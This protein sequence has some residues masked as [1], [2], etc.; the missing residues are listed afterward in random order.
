MSFVYPKIN[1]VEN[2][3]IEK[4]YTET[5]SKYFELIELLS[6]KLITNYGQKALQLID[7]NLLKTLVAIREYYKVP[8]FIN[9]G[10]PDFDERIVRFP[11]SEV[12]SPGSRHSAVIDAKGNITKRSDACDFDVKGMTAEQVRNDIR[13]N[14]A[15]FTLITAIE[16]GVGWVHIDLRKCKKLFEFSK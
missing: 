10:T 14:L 7:I 3:E 1:F 8:M 11:D 13:K 4:Y 6:P 15:P 12:Y 2:S 5:A 16:K 9:N